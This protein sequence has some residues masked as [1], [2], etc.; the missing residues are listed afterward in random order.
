VTA[1]VGA[2]AFIP[3]AVGGNNPTGPGL[4]TFFVN[5]I[6]TPSVANNFPLVQNF[7]ANL[8]THARD[9]IATR[10]QSNI[11]AGNVGGPMVK[12]AG[13]RTRNPDQVDV[14]HL[15]NQ[16]IM[17]G[18]THLNNLAPSAAEQ[19]RIQLKEAISSALNRMAWYTTMGMSTV[20][21]AHWI[22]LLENKLNTHMDS[23]FSL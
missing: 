6:T 14:L 9:P 7:P 23:M 3:V 11:A 19:R 4:P 10:Q 5:A 20:A 15:M 18:I 2:S 13:T 22:K 12:K 17:Q 8:G 1:G 21:I 16:Q